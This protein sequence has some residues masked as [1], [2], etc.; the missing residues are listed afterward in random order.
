MSAKKGNQNVKGK[1]WKLSDETKQRQ[2]LASKK[3][4]EDPEFRSKTCEA[5]S[6]TKNTPEK[7]EEQSR[8]SKEFHSRP[9]V[10]EKHKKS[11][12]EWANTPE[13]LE[14]RKQFMLNLW[15]EQDFINMMSDSTK[16]L[17]KNSEYRTKVVEGIKKAY[18]NPELKKKFAEVSKNL[19]KDP[20][21]RMKITESNIKTWNDSKLLEEHSIIMKEIFK[22]PIILKELSERTI[23]LWQDPIYREKVISSLK[24]TF[25]NPEVIA[26]RSGKNSHRYGV[27]PSHGKKT[28]EILTPFQGLKKMFHWDYLLAKY[29]NEIDAPYLYEPQAFPI[30]INERDYTYTPDFFIPNLNIFIEIK[31][32]WRG[33]GKEKSEEFL[34]SY[35]EHNYVVWFGKDLQ[36]LGINLREV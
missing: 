6:I 33:L 21:F 30:K 1:H 25:K 11:L 4:W 34:K 15:Q 32:Y 17:W 14:R 31:G 12:K 36:N 29:M 13:E 5:I 9:E 28:Y 3:K 26:K 35:P 8:I 19:W 2:S 16:N 18:E 24:E 22:D 7:K 10:K 23:K 27:I 20:D